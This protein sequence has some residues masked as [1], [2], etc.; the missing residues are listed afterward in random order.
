MELHCCSYDNTR[1]DVHCYNIIAAEAQRMT[2]TGLPEDSLRD[3]LSPELSLPILPEYQVSRAQVSRV[4][5]LFFIVRIERVE[6]SMSFPTHT[7]LIY[8]NCT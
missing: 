8:E 5:Y 4:L 3:L 7:S 1:G 2:T 6:F